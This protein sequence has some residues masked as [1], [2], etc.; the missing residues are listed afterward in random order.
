MKRQI[1]TIR[2]TPIMAEEGRLFIN[3]SANE[4]NYF[5]EVLRNRCPEVW[6]SDETEEAYWKRGKEINEQAV[7]LPP[8][9]PWYKKIL[10]L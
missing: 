3:G 1:A 7:E 9:V 10:P 6:F 4:V 8:K 2:G 5:V